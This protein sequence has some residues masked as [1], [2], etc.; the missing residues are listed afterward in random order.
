[1]FQCFPLCPDAPYPPLTFPTEPR[2]DPTKS[3]RISGALSPFPVLFQHTL[4]FSDVPYASLTNP[5]PLGFPE[6]PIAL[7]ASLFERSQRS[8]LP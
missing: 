8:P 2:R 7:L 6:H 3:R 5:I 4:P 1:M